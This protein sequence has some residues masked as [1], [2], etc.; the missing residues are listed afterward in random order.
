MKSCEN[1]TRFSSSNFAEICLCPHFSKAMEK[2]TLPKGIDPKKSGEN[3]NNFLMSYRVVKRYSRSLREMELIDF[4]DIKK[5]NIFTLTDKSQ[6]NYHTF[7]E[8]SQGSPDSENGEIDYVAIEDARFLPN[9]HDIDNW[10][11]N[12]EPIENVIEK[13]H[14]DPMMDIP[15]HSYL[16]IDWEDYKFWLEHTTNGG[17]YVKNQHIL[18]L[19]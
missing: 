15:L 7:S 5:G 10:V 2:I 1:C 8:Q 19:G 14:T 16:H 4:K 6:P 17:K 9:D 13:W 11:V 3:C 12:C 18:V